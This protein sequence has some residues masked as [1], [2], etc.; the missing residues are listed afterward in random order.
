MASK[1]FTAGNAI[2]ILYIIFSWVQVVCFN[3]ANPDMI[4][5]YNF[6]RLLIERAL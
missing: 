5:D 4:S 6:F 3:T 1:F 2:L